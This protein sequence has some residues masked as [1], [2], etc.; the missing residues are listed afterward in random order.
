MT[1]QRQEQKTVI[2]RIDHFACIIV[3]TFKVTVGDERRREDEDR[4]DGQEMQE[5]N[6][7]TRKASIRIS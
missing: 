3:L 6:I 7:V 2:F 5:L 1:N 4:T